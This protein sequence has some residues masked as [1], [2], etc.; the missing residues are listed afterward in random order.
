MAYTDFPP[1]DYLILNNYENCLF[2]SKDLSINSDHY[3]IDKEI[4]FSEEMI[5]VEFA[6]I[7]FSNTK[8]IVVDLNSYNYMPYIIVGNPSSH[9]YYC[10][11]YNNIED[12]IN[13]Q[14]LIEYKYIKANYHLINLTSISCPDDTPYISILFSNTVFELIKDY[15][16]VQ[17]NEDIKIPIS[18][19]THF[20]NIITPDNTKKY[21]FAFSNNENLQDLNKTKSDRTRILFDKSNNYQFKLNHNEEIQTELKIRIFE[22]KEEIEF[23]II[24]ENEISDF[25]MINDN[26]IAIKYYINLLKKK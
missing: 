3:L 9:L 14:K 10:S 20:F 8:R 21:I 4:P 13:K 22:I 7:Y 17:E 2:N 19:E 23:N 11:Q 24:K 5:S 1:D 6:W 16:I 12:I 15:R 26:N 25:F 18:K